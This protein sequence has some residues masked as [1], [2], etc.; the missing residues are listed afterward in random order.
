MNDMPL[1]R[2][3]NGLNLRSRAMSPEHDTDPAEGPNS[4]GNGTDPLFPPKIGKQGPKQ[5]HVT[6]VQGPGT[7]TASRDPRDATTTERLLTGLLDGPQ[8]KIADKP[9]KK[10]SSGDDAAA[11][12]ASPRPVPVA[13]KADEEPAVIVAP[14]SNRSGR[15]SKQAK[16][17]KSTRDEPTVELPRTRRR[18]LLP[19]LLAAAGAL[20]F[21][22]AYLALRP[23][24]KV[25]AP[26]PTAATALAV[27]PMAQIPP[28][29]AIPAPTPT[30]TPTP[31]D[32][33]LPEPLI[34]S[35]TIVRPPRVIVTNPVPRAPTTATASATPAPP[36]SAVPPPPPSAPAS[37]VAPSAAPDFDELKKGIKH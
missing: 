24:P 29:E 1:R 13:H 19:V 26:M 21:L 36:A 27:V 16:A 8:P 25:S 4:N 33:A 5:V 12:S 10:D 7:Q 14:S 9:R 28:P 30:P 15:R 35:R 31:T 2:P 32:D 6:A 11:Y 23:R 3:E 20:L 18:R 34:E 17:A 37:A 22:F